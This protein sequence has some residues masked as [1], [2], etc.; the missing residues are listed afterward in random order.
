M[1][2]MASGIV[3]SLHMAMTAAAADITQYGS[4]T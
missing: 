3:G 1:V 2:I 4:Y